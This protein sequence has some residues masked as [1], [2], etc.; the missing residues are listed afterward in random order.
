MSAM[1]RFLIIIATVTLVCVPNVMAQNADRNVLSQV[2]ESCPVE[3]H[4][5]GDGGAWC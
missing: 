3:D 5:V 2:E 4:N 1:S